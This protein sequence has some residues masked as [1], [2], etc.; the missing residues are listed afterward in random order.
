[1]KPNLLKKRLHAIIQEYIASEDDYYDGKENFIND[2]NSV[3]KK[4]GDPGIVCSVRFQEAV[5]SVREIGDEIDC[6]YAAINCK[7]K[8][9]TKL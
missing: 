1:M 7:K 6:I 9:A 3:F 4:E 2:C 8:T 5:E